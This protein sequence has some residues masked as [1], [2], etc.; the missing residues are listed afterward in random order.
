MISS[1]K[2]LFKKEKK[3]Y[4]CSGLLPGNVKYTMPPV[5]K[6]RRSSNSEWLEVTKENLMNV[7][8]A[9]FAKS[10]KIPYY[11]IYRPT[12]EFAKEQGYDYFYGLPFLSVLDLNRMEIN[13]DKKT[14]IKRR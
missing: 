11:L 14:N 7:D 3:Y 13:N 9:I 1:V 8:V 5:L 4:Q 2:R 6:T 12:Y 10:I